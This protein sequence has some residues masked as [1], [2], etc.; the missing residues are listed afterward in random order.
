MMA[1]APMPTDEPLTAEEVATLPDG[2]SIIVV[3]SGGNGPHRYTVRREAGVPIAATDWEVTHDRLDVMRRLDNPF[4][5]IG[6]KRYHTRVWRAP[7]R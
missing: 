6:Q 5:F 7:E 3:W 1:S 4:G 2:A